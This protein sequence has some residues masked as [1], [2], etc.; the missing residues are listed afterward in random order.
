[1]IDTTEIFPWNDNFKTGIALIDK[2]HRRLV[3]LINMLTSHI[4]HQ[5]D[6]PALNSIF[7]ELSEYA[8]YHFRAEEKIW[9]Q[10][11]LGDELETEHKQTHRNFIET[12]HGLKGEENTK[13]QE[14]VVA[15]ILSFLTHWL[16]YHILDNDMNMAK[17]V[18]G[19]QSGLSLEEA[20]IQAEGEMSGA[21]K[22]LIE[23][24]LLMYDSLSSR[25]LH[26]MKEIIERQ[27]AETKLRLAANVFENTLDTICITDAKANIVDINPSFCQTC[28]L[29]REE[30]LGKNLKTLKSGFNDQ[31]FSLALWETVNIKGYW[32]GEIRNR[33]PSGKLETE[34]L[35]LSSIRDERG[36]ITNYVG[37]FSNVSQLFQRQH[38]LEFIAGHDAL[39][40]LPNRVLLADR[41]ELAIA[42]AERSSEIF[43]VCY[44]DL[45]GFKP[46]N[47]RLG[48]AA[49]DQLL[50]EIAKRFKSVVR[51]N[52]T[53]ARVGGDEFVIVLG[54]MKS[55]DECKV[56]LDRLL[57]EISRPIHI[58]NETA[59]VTTSIGVAIF[60]HDGSDSESLLKLADQAMYL[61]KNSGK[62]RYHFAQA[63]D[64]WVRNVADSS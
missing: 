1:M 21:M 61:A 5:S 57:E 28:D 20:K 2:Q 38:K 40:G 19:I 27:R 54:K 8:D 37:V 15:D 10:Y 34:W 64:D 60:P 50:C 24:V 48:H 56:I 3:D 12:L 22:V 49:G 47:D 11:F 16:A 9:S 14:Q 53:V 4:T 41:L 7:T 32:C 25:T 6:I 59:H 51:S 39:T 30:L 23:T 18:L 63:F 31:D 26:L 36:A 55:P 35:T 42:N 58:G 45:D 44:L 17:I 43:A 52:D 29:T 46:V 33:K 13:P 62:C